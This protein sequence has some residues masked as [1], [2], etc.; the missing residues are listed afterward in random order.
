MAGRSNLKHAMDNMIEAEQA[1]AESGEQVKQAATIEAL[2]YGP[3]QHLRDLLIER[4]QR[5]G[6]SVFDFTWKEIKETLG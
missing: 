6:R 1:V 5:E 3:D 4:A 2:L